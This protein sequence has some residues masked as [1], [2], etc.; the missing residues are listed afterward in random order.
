MNE[1]YYVC[2]KVNAAH[3]EWSKVNESQLAHFFSS[4]FNY[5]VTSIFKV[6]LDENTQ[7]LRAIEEKKKNI[8]VDIEKLEKTA[9]KLEE[10]LNSNEID[11]SD[12]AKLEEIKESIAKTI[13]NLKKEYE[14][15]DLFKKKVA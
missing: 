10:S 2:D 8:R 15:V 3:R 1:S 5:D 9:H 7:T 4:K 12:V 14:Q 13:L 11:R 6:K